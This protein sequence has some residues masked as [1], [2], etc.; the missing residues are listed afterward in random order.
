MAQDNRSCGVHRSTACRSTRTNKKT[1]RSGS[2]CTTWK[3][4]LLLGF[5]GSGVG[6][7]GDVLSG[8]GGS[9]GS[10]SSGVGGSGSSSVGS[11]VHGFTGSGSSGFGAFDSSVASSDSGVAGSSSGVASSSGGIASSV[12]SLLGGSG[13][14][15]RSVSGFFFL[16]GRESE[17]AGGQED[18][19]LG[20][21]DLSKG[22][23]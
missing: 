3:Q 21:H 15:S 22:V 14:F 11:L 23:V 20:V 12:G 9:L 6:L 5:F 13:G 7:V 10:V 8:V 16:A 1:R 17:D 18:E 4:E 2:F 19:K